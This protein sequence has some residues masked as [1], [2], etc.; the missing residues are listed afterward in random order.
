MVGIYKITNLINQKVYIGQSIDILKRWNAHKYRATLS[1]K[2]YPEY[3]YQAI[4]KYGIENFSFEII[5]ECKEEELDEKE[6][7]WILFYN[8]H[9][10]GYNMILP[11]EG[12]RDILILAN[13]KRMISILAYS[14][15]GEF[16]KEYKSIAEASRDT[17]VHTYVIRECLNKNNQRGGSFQ[18]VK[19]ENNDI[20]PSK[21]PPYKRRKNAGCIKIKQY[22][23][24]WNLINIFDSI[25][26]AQKNTGVSRRSIMRVCNGEQLSS[27]GF[28]W[29][30]EEYGS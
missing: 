1:E 4:R 19:K 26:D 17:G 2:E 15:E 25:L 29:R 28:I 21:I 9:K 12:N 16:V 24:E 13:K 14:L 23:L 3:I 20:I 8:S 27:K 11:N 18:W 10:K 30:K 5:E 22:D 6:L 7:K